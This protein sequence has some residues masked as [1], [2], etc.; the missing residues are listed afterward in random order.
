MVDIRLRQVFCPSARCAFYFNRCGE[1]EPYDPARSSTTPFR[2]FV[3]TITSMRKI[4]FL[5]IDGV[6]NCVTT[7]QRHRGAI[8]ID[9]YM[10][11]LVRRIVDA[12]GCEVVLSSSWRHFPG[13][14]EEVENQVCPIFDVTPTSSTGFRGDEIRVWLNAHPEVTRYAIVDDNA[15]MLPEQLPNFFKTSWTE[16]LSEDTQKEIIRHLNSEHVDKST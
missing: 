6:V 7:S 4:L 14:R 3:H 15:D 12:T 10:A 5:D 8:G 2:D 16:G 1:I 13:G 11:C 9:P